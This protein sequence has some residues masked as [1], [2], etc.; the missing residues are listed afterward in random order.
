MN[1][2]NNETITYGEKQKKVISKNEDGI[3]DEKNECLPGTVIY[4]ND[5]LGYMVINKPSGM[6]VAPTVDN[7]LE[8]VVSCVGRAI[9]HRKIDI[10]SKRN[11]SSMVSS[12]DDKYSDDDHNK[13]VDH[14]APEIYVACPQRLDQNTSVSFF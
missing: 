3:D 6:S 10:S 4:S 8:N 13:V 2:G 12:R 7:L 14:N 1:K 9:L 5:E 11:G